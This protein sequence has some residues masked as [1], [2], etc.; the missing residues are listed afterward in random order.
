MN[1]GLST[2]IVNIE[3][4]K[5]KNTHLKTEIINVAS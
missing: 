2:Y 5:G 3:I 4:M 1:S